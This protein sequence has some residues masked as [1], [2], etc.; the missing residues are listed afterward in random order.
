M[1]WEAFC[2][3][4]TEE[5]GSDEFKLEMH[6]LLQLRQIGSVIEYRAAFDAHIYHLLALE[7][8]LSPKFFI[9]VL[10]CAFRHRRASCGRQSWRTYMRSWG[11]SDRA[12]DLYLPAC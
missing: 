1:A 4:I 10:R 8:S 6:K 12:L 7:P 5:F 11:H 9:T 2:A 3:A